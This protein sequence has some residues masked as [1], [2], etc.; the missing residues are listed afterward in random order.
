MIKDTGHTLLYLPLYSHERSTNCLIDALFSVTI[1][2][3]FGYIAEYIH[4]KPIALMVFNGTCKRKQFVIWV[5]G[6][7]IKEL[8][9]RQSVI[10]EYFIF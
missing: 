5:G 9:P 7:L 8:H 2:Y 1:L 3:L 4:H 10:N 6:V